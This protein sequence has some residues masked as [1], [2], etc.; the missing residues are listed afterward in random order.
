M[1]SVV[2]GSG[3]IG[4]VVG[5]AMAAAGEDVLL[6]DIVPEHVRSMNEAGL[7]IRSARDEQRVPV[8]AALPAQVTGT[9]D[10]VFLAVKSQF[11]HAALD[12]IEPHLGPESAM[13][14]LQ[15]GV[16][17]PHIANRI[18]AE[19]TIGCLVDFSADYHAPGEIM[20]ARAGNL[21]IGEMDGRMSP[22]L[23]EIHRLCAFS[24]RTHSCKNIMGFVW[25]KMCKATVDSMTA[26]VDHNS[27]ELRADQ[28]YHPVRIQLLREAIK[29]AVASGVRVEVFAHFDPAPFL[30]TSPEGFAAAYA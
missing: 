15:N 1:K 23:A 5:A 9:F 16:N 25:A 21:Y 28:T 24:T 2:W 11:T 12:A 20:R 29:V 27:L 6:V 19:R 8:R 13:I 7:V 18:G 4:G 26:L 10:L 14:S 30:D 17:E 3:A 22:R